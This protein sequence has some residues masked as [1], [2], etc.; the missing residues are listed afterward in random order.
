MSDTVCDF[1][2]TPVFDV[3]FVVGVGSCVAVGAGATETLDI[4]VLVVDGDGWRVGETRSRLTLPKREGEL[5]SVG[6]VL[7]E[8]LTAT[9][10]VNDFVTVV[11]TEPMNVALRLRT[12]RLR[13][14]RDTSSDRLPLPEIVRLCE[15]SFTSEA[16]CEASGVDDAESEGDCDGVADAVCVLLWPSAVCD[17][18]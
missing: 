3:R 15:T 1:E 10:S 13:V 8:R 4:T 9:V 18:E 5:L 16:V 17:V 12:V 14:Y 7:Y 2:G 11:S 6:L